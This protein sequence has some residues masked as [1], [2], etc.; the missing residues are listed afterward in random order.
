MIVIPACAPGNRRAPA[1]NYGAYG[2]GNGRAT[3]LP[4]WASTRALEAGPLSGNAPEV[5]RD[6]LPSKET[7]P[8]RVDICVT[9]EDSSAAPERRI[10]ADGRAL[11]LSEAM[12][13]TFVLSMC[14]SGGTRWLP[15]DSVEAG[16]TY[17][18]SVK[19]ELK[20]ASALDES[21]CAWAGTT[22]GYRLTS[23]AADC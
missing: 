14:S 13:E 1:R 9:T 2:G 10:D 8:P 22:L 11:W 17:E 7:T 23:T 5:R 15:A 19:G 4:T 3:S 12:T 21:T 6:S 20:F 18:S 16:L